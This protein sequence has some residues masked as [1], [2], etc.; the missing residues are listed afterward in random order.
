MVRDAHNADA[1]QGTYQ[2]SD[3]L[4]KCSVHH[5]ALSVAT[6]PVEVA[7]P[8][9]LSRVRPTA[10]GSEACTVIM[11]PSAGTKPS[12]IRAIRPYAGKRMR[13]VDP[14]LVPCTT[15]KVTVQLVLLG[16]STDRV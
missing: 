1:Y 16:L 6:I 7:A 13:Q 11:P 10:T 14:V 15:E 3:N 4:I 5:P 12:T 8:L 9:L 2:R